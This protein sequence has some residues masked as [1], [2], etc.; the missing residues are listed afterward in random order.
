MLT[1]VGQLVTAMP[2]TRNSRGKEGEELLKNGEAGLG[3]EQPFKGTQHA[4]RCMSRE[5]R[6]NSINDDEGDFLLGQG[7]RIKMSKRNRMPVRR[8]SVV[9]GIGSFLFPPPL[10][11]YF[12]LTQV[13]ISCA[14]LTR[15]SFPFFYRTTE[16]SRD[17]R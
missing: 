16:P 13:F 14:S 3:G 17:S 1:F 11:F 6:A 7:L 2:A 12:L 15:P 10:Y 9:N 5:P 4:T 8:V